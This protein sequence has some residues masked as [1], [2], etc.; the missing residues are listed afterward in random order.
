[1]SES[2]DDVG[3]KTTSTDGDSEPLCQ[4][5]G[6]KHANKHFICLLRN[7]ESW[8]L[9]R[10]CTWNF[11]K[12]SH[13]AYFMRQQELNWW[14]AQRRGGGGESVRRLKWISLELQESE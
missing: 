6:R 14:G 8:S 10:V 4:S 3:Q 12:V 7:D 1:M 2:E 5:E 9:L 13:H 11:E